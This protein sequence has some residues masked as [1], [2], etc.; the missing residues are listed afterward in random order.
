MEERGSNKRLVKI[1]RRGAKY[2][3]NYK[4]KDE[5]IC[6]IDVLAGRFPFTVFFCCT[7]FYG[8]VSISDYVVSN[9]RMSDE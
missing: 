5:E 3:Y 6:K 8:A 1:I 4:I 2:Y 7:L 9:G